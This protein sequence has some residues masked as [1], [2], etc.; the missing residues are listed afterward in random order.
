MKPT[1][2]EFKET[3]NQ[4]MIDEDVKHAKYVM[5]DRHRRLVELEKELETLHEAISL[6]EQNIARGDFHLVA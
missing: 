5:K 2:D 6:A 1:L 3:L 4:E